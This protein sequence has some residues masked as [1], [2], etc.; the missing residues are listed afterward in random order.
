M[1]NTAQNRNENS[2]IYTKK[3][4]AKLKNYALFMN[5]DVGNCEK[6]IKNKKIKK[7]HGLP[8]SGRNIGKI[9]VK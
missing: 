6:C 5:K 1:P 9:L 3:R 7:I 2:D 8:K 4:N